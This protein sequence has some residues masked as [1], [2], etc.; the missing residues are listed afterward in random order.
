MITLKRNNAKNP[1]PKFFR[2]LIF[3]T[4]RR[5]ETSFSQ[6][7]DQFNSESTRAKS[8]WG[9]IT[10]LYGKILAFNLCFALNSILG[11]HDFARIKSL[12]F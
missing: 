10:R 8:L 5:I 7:E 11:I 6:L 3:K 12:V 2:Q 1:D 9:L 4:R